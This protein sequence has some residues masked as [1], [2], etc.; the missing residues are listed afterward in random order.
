M[1]L[2]PAFLRLLLL[3]ALFSLPPEKIFSQEIE[4]V[5]LEDLMEKEHP[6]HQAS[7]KYIFSNCDVK[8][9]ENAAGFTVDIN[10]HQRI[11]I[12][13]EKGLDYANFEIPL[14]IGK[15]GSKEKLIQIK[16]KVYNLTETG[17]IMASGMDKK[18]I[19]EEEEKKYLI[20]KFALPKVK[21][22]SIIEVDYTIRSPFVYLIPK[23]Y[24]QKDVPVDYSSYRVRLNQYASYTP[25][26]RGVFPIELEI[27][28]KGYNENNYHYYAKDIPPMKEDDFVLNL[29]DYRSNI[30][31]ELHSI[32][33]PGVFHKDYTSDWNSIC[34]NLSSSDRFGIHLRKNLKQ[35]NDLIDSCSG[36]SQREKAETIFAYVRD[37][38]TWN[39][40]SS[41]YPEK[42]MKKFTEER[43]GNVADFNI[44]LIGLLQKAGL[45]SYPIL[46]KNRNRGVFNAAIP[47]L[48]ELN[49]VLAMVTVDGMDL[50]LDASDEN[51]RFGMLPKRAMNLS[52]ILMDMQN[53]QVVDLVNPNVY[54]Y[55]KNSTLT[56]NSDKNIFEGEG[57]EMYR[58]YASKR[59]RDKLSKSGI[60]EDAEE[61]IEEEVEDIFE[62][63]ESIGV[64]DKDGD[65]DVLFNE[66]I[67]KDIVSIGDQVLINGDLNMGIEENPFLK[68]ER[69]FPV[70]FPYK[71]DLRYVSTIT[72]PE[73]VELE[74]MPEPIVY[75]MK[76]NQGSFMYDAK[77]FGNNLVINYAFK[78]NADIILPSDYLDLKT[79]Y[80]NALQKRTEKIILKKM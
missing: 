16:T 12:Y 11:K 55:L 66:T 70:F 79:M 6:V 44:L 31:L 39:G 48:S 77:H 26:V 75:M 40:E 23:W 19:Y 15:A 8:L 61:E 28:E 71:Y 52:G 67:Q 43:V 50:V 59:Y 1:K 62:A 32:N 53:V 49:Y 25:I 18:E 30:K 78:I 58:S 64:S 57:Q 45:G 35:H 76:D 4:E 54:K 3:S 41:I 80:E 27:K 37:N 47:S 5:T 42:G 63:L 21:Q 10:V 7:A 73:D 46:T 69:E 34:T 72:L 20:K 68:E 36:K 9:N 60:E 2:Y 51:C 74:S 65:I 24:F 33:I 22:G 38:F 56:F 29:N 14:Y 17:K 13:D